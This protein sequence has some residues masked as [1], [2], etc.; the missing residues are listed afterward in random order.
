MALSQLY[1]G[2]QDPHW[3]ADEVQVVAGN[4]E[5]KPPAVI[6]D[7][8]ETVLDNSAYNARNI[9]RKLPYT[10]DSWNAWCQE[11]RAD[12]IPGALDFIKRAEALGVKVFYVT[13]RRDVVKRDGKGK[14][15]ASQYGRQQQ[16]R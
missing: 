8:D 1:V 5:D 9:I 13:N 6:L 7:C 10:T 4:Y 3:S 16:L 11:G 14:R 12:A 2:M 15:G